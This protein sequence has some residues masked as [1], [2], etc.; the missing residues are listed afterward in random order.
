M[1][2]ARHTQSVAITRS[3]DVRLTVLGSGGDVGKRC[4]GSCRTRR[5]NHGL[6]PV[7]LPALQSLMN[8]L[9]SAPVNCFAVACLEQEGFEDVVLEADEALDVDFELE[10]V[11]EELAGGLSANAAV[12]PRSAVSAR[13][14]SSLMMATEGGRSCTSQ[15]G[16]P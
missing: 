4:G 16:P 5:T 3:S 12:V 7:V 2:N 13:A 8:C 9:R 6:Q 1:P 10:G 11:A 15:P 14:E